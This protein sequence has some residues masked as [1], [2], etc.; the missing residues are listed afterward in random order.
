MLVAGHIVVT[1]IHLRQDCCVL[2]GS[3]QG[4]IHQL[5]ALSSAYTNYQHQ[6]LQLGL[7]GV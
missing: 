6:L 2:D 4:I 1:S 7:L 3:S 5:D